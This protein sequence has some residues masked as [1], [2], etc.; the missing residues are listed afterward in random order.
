MG[1][2]APSPSALTDEPTG[3]TLSRFLRQ[4]PPEITLLHDA[5]DRRL[6][7]VEASDMDDPTDYLLDEEM[8][9]T[10]GFPLLGHEND[11]D[12]V[13][14]FIAR[15]A[16]AKVSALGFGLEPYF[17]E[18]PATV[19]DACR[20]NNLP[21]LEIPATV[22]FAAIGIAFA[23]LLEADSA[24]RLRTSAEAH[25]ALMRC[26]THKDPEAEL[27]A[28]LSQRL[29]ASVRLL[30][31]Q[32]QVRHEASIAENATPNHDLSSELFTQASNSQKFAMRSEDSLVDLAF[33]LR[34]TMTAGTHPPVLGVLSVGFARTPSASDHNLITTALGLLDVLARQRVTSSSTTEQLATTLL[35]HQRTPLDPHTLNLLRNSLGSTTADSVRVAVISPLNNIADQD[36]DLHLPHLQTLLATELVALNADHFVALTST[37]PTHELFEHLRSSGYLAVFS[38]PEPADRQLGEKLPD[39]LAQATGLLPQMR[40][41]RQS[42]DA[43]AIARSFASLLPP[44]AGKQLAEELLAP[45]LDLPEVRRDLYLDVLR[46]WL[47]ANGSWDQTSKNIDLHRNSVRRHIANIGEILDK[48]LNHAAVRQ[49][50]YLALSFLANP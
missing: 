37:E 29:K 3:I 28:T 10:S 46:G 8:I 44:E 13:R 2:S 19:L 7:W 49:D 41:K 5:G 14:A 30:D 38:V 21:L 16:Q 17:T 45:L 4:L 43:S 15:L 24:A 48:D 12:E 25:R 47:E 18:V 32:G 26:L 36:P 20:E 6:R 27:I 1:H 40:E 50:L 23:Q 35:L 39:L 22:P 33:P 34:A 9:L 42:L 31:A 11:P